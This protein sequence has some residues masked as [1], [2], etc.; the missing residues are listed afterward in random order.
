MIMERPEGIVGPIM[1]I[2]SSSVYGSPSAL[3]HT[4]AKRRMMTFIDIM[5]DAQ[6]EHVGLSLQPALINRN[7]ANIELD[8]ALQATSGDLP[9]IMTMGG[10]ATVVSD[11]LMHQNGT[12]RISKTELA[13]RL[14]FSTNRWS[15]PSI[16]RRLVRSVVVTKAHGVVLRGDSGMTDNPWIVERTMSTVGQM[17]E[18][19][20]T[21]A[22]TI[23]LEI[24]RRSH[25]TTEEYLDHI[26][27][28]RDKYGD[29]FAIAFDTAHMAQTE[30]N[31][32][33]I[34]RTGIAE[35]AFEE[36]VIMGKTEGF[37]RPAVAIVEL[38]PVSHDGMS[39]VPLEDN[40]VDWRRIVKTWEE[41][42][43]GPKPSDHAPHHYVYEPHPFRYPGQPS[44]VEALVEA[45]E[46]LRYHLPV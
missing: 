26:L 8:P 46:E 18:D 2:D 5:R 3:R 41:L 16:V 25:P 12:H 21:P 7:G 44:E 27:R 33:A 39:H 17:M 43:H 40:I 4:V 28:L 37:R 11:R 42:E 24:N 34:A 35:E 38:N 45:F 15:Y 31:G 36:V 32:G 23:A 10:L 19:P 13:G 29:I 14:A 30:G 1:S 6:W 22:V 20:E 9:G